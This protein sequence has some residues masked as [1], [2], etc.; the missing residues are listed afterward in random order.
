MNFIGKT[1]AFIVSSNLTKP[2]LMTFL[3]Q[4]IQEAANVQI[5]HFK[6]YWTVYCSA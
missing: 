4:M 6:G 2:L 5:Q 1:L 3:Q